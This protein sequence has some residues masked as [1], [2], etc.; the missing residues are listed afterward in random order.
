[1]ARL[2]E[3][4][5]N[6]RH[7][8]ERA[9]QLHLRDTLPQSW[10]ITTN[11]KEHHFK[12]LKGGTVHTEIDSILICPFGIFI[13]DFKNDA[14]RITPNIKSGWV[15]SNSGPARERSGT[16]PF[17][18]CE[19]KQFVLKK[20]LSD[21]DP[22]LG[23]IWLKY[24]IVLTRGTLS[25]TGSDVREKN[26]LRLQVVELG[27]VESNV[28]LISPRP[29]RKLTSATVRQV[30]EALKGPRLPGDL[31][32]SFA[33]WGLDRYYLVGQVF[34]G[35]VASI[36]AEGATIEIDSHTTGRLDASNISWRQVEYPIDLL[37]IGQKIAV[38]I[39][40]IDPVTQD[41]SLGAKQLQDDPLLKLI[42]GGTV[43]G[44]I[45]EVT[46]DGAT[47]EL[48]D[49]VG[50]L[51]ATD[52]TWS[53][54]ARPSEL[55]R[56]D[57]RINAKIIG[58]DRESRTIS[59]GMKQLEDDPLTKLAVGD[60]RRAVVTAVSDDRNC[61]TVDLG[62]VFGELAGAEISWVSR[63]LR[64]TEL[65]SVKQEVDVQILAIDL[66]RRSVAVSRKCLLPNPWKKFASENV[67][68][69]AVRGVIMQKS[70]AGLRIAL[71]DGLEG[72]IDLPDL[73]WYRPAAAVLQECR[74]NEEIRMRVLAVDPV[75]Q[76]ISLG[77]LSTLSAE[78]RRLQV[79]LRAHVCDLMSQPRLRIGASRAYCERGDAYA[80]NREFDR[81]IEDF[82]EAVRL[83]PASSVGYNR[84]GNAYYSKGDYAHA[85][86]SYNEAIRLNAGSA[87]QYTNR[88]N[89]CRNKG[90]H[91]RAL[92]DCDQ[93]LRLDP[94]YIRAW[95]ARGD[96][97]FKRREYDKA[98]GDY[99]RSIA[100]NGNDGLV[101]NARGVCHFFKSDFDRAIADFDEAIRLRPDSA[102]E[103]ANRGDAYRS[104]KEYERAIKDY[105]EALRISP[106]YGPAVRA[107]AS[108]S[109][110]I[111]TPS[112]R[113]S[114]DPVDQ[115]PPSDQSKPT[116]TRKLTL[117]PRTEQGTVRQN[118]SHG[119]TKQVV[120]ERRS[121]LPRPPTAPVME[122]SAKSPRVVPRSLSAEERIPRAEAIIEARQTLDEE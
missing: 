84:R 79:L 94:N 119:R 49:L 95:N 33:Q 51:D 1:M 38:K 12:H 32:E 96:S 24:L 107:K 91:D 109:G 52:M 76:R 57:Q 115:A 26:A 47:V 108:L 50:R 75:E 85:I 27:E 10:Y 102:P 70:E 7:P 40:G 97:H 118:F 8:A 66:D 90:E 71:D 25:W 100:L 87:V 64:P 59:L 21:H 117:W 41:I 15:S 112:T 73:G 89:A 98:I 5:K 77:M 80:A 86:E 18:Q 28:R 74:L 54:T 122:V 39:I 105:D 42:V 114:V 29:D 48:R 43:S 62:G 111:A 3:I 30:V 35:I 99:D 44:K 58:I 72:L 69:G 110:Q 81:A 120:V 116:E 113:S 9:A 78:R 103:Y 46:S 93:A 92:E 106:D 83:D 14:G 68:G 63:G 16:N 45:I 20:L 2:I 31:L 88:A 53:Q 121:R 13:I 36:D 60:R 56:K 6:A 101:F 37:R 82:A 65:L 34:P 55:L 17:E 19:D 61:A 23:Q 22:K 4:D 67:P 104:K 11:M